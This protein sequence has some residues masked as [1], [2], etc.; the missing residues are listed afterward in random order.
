M[1]TREKLIAKINEL[2]L[3]IERLKKELI[4]ETKNE[5]NRRN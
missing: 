4:K 5:N 2:Y 1:T 3:E